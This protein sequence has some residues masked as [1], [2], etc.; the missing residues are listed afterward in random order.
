MVRAGS[1]KTGV[2]VSAVGDVG[3]WDWFGLQLV[4]ASPPVTTTAAL[5]NWRRGRDFE[6][7]LRFMIIPLKIAEC[8]E[9]KYLGMFYLYF[10]H[11]A[12][13]RIRILRQPR[14]K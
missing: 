4:S 6:S 8:H 1:L 10:A 3:S 12:I 7:W 5:R 9:A 13:C 14:S 2:P 11:F